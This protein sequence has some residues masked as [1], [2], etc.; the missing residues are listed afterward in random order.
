MNY[1]YLY[2][3]EYKGQEKIDFFD[4]LKKSI[5]V[6]KRCTIDPKIFVY[7]HEDDTEIVGYC[8]SN[9]INAVPIKFHRPFHG[10]IRILV[11]KIFILRDFPED[12]EIVLLDVDTLFRYNISDSIWQK[13]P[14]LWDAEYYITQFRNLDKVLPFLP[15]YEIDINFDTTYVMYNTG[16]VYIPKE[17]RREIC[18][19]ALWITDRLNDGKNPDFRYG[20]KLD[21]QIGLSI[22]IHEKYR[23]NGG[24]AVCKDMIDHFWEAKTQGL[25]WWK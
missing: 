6:L 18:Q 13:H 1:A 22:A 12:E 25:I 3:N 19:K 4:Q 15:W 20:N 16:V 7:H 17:H 8:N 2:V 9:R 21:E 5:E 14:I 11:E 10:I 24:I 23:N